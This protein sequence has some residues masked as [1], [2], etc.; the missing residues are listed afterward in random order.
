MKMCFQKLGCKLIVFF[1]GFLFC[2]LLGSP[3]FAATLDRVVAK[4]NNDVITLGTL[5]DRVAVFS[6]RMETSGSVD[7][8]LAKK[9]LM[10]TILDEMIAEKL[11]TQEAKKLG[12]KVAEK[13]LEE[14]LDDLYNSNNITSEQFKEM[15]K[16]EG[17]D[18]E[19]YKEVIR[20]QILIARIRNN[21]IGSGAVKERSIR[22]YYRKNKKD[23]WVPGKIIAS[24][25]MLIKE[26]GSSDNEIQ[27][28]KK[29]A[30]EILQQIQGG[31][32]F[33]EL[34]KKYSEDVSAH[35]GGEL[36]AID[37]GTM[38]PAFENAAFNLK[39]GEVSKVVETAN[40]FHI[41]KCDNVIPGYVKEYKIVRAEIESILSS[42]K[43][44]QKYQEW[45]KGLKKV[46]FIEISLFQDEKKIKKV[47]IAGTSERRGSSKPQAIINSDRYL[48]NQ[49]KP[50]SNEGLSKERFIEE[51]LK[52]YKKLYDDGKISKKIFLRK[53]RQL[54]EKL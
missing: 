23:Y 25:I 50:N 3:I 8:Q 26:N 12:M 39:I 45:L 44:K 9:K 22:K 38:M 42:K 27:F 32:G 35:S 28:K 1:A 6:S 18:L 34:A 53:K 37:R 41:I 13:T 7:E 43:R 4:V 52:N 30:E 29:K 17:S 33:S 11:Q 47:R 24:H 14:A 21:I 51:K 40:G 31:E 46:S 36:G 16:N 20:D 2:F 54:L 10:K 49:D 5:E 19:A 48:K 15:L